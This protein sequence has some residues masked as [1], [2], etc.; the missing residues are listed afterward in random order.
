MMKKVFLVNFL[1]VL[2]AL[3]ACSNS[4]TEGSEG[5][6]PSQSDNT[7]NNEENNDSPSTNVEE[8]SRE[9]SSATADSTILST[10]EV[11]NEIKEV[12]KMKES[13]LPT[14]FPITDTEFVT[15]KINKNEENAYSVSFYQTNE[16]IPINDA[17]LNNSSEGISL[18][19]TV[20]GEM[21]DDPNKQQELFPTT[22]LD[23]IPEEMAVDLGQDIV[24]IEEGA[25]G[26][27]YLQWKEGRWIF[28]IKTLSST[29]LDNVNIARKM[30]D[31]LEL[32]ALPVPN[33]N[34]RFEVDYPENA[35]N[36][37]V[38]SRFEEGNIVYSIK[39][40]EVPIDTL[41]MT[42]VTE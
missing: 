19:A 18:L 29:T 41:M 4:P 36:V 6:E 28:Q 37:E 10:N 40:N 3:T 30:V 17:T 1:V 35:A 12:L 32:N 9:N 2:L 5:K 26:S 34:G 14:K 8:T 33:E 39:T 27:T 31:Y 25:A 22:S 13:K 15:A 7:V 23:N 21:Y 24:G 42:V 38:T 20:E 16:F 11:I